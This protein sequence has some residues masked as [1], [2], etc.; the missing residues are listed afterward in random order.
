MN[1]TALERILRVIPVLVDGPKPL[2]RA[3]LPFEL[4]S[5]ERLNALELSY[6]RY[7]YDADRLL[8]IIERVLPQPEAAAP[9]RGCA[10]SDRS[11]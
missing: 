7:H 5:L 11:S 1:Q 10:A 8:K 9:N 3:Q 2:Q 6:G 4:H